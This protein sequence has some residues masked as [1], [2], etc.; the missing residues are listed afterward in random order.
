[1]RAF[2]FATSVL[3]GP[4]RSSRDEALSD[5]VK[6]RQAVANRSFPEGLEW[7]V[8]GRIEAVPR[9]AAPGGARARPVR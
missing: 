9:D 6:A 1:M 4:W 5:A 2:R 8:T 3:I 7:R